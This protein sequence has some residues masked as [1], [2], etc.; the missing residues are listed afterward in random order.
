[1]FRTTEEPLGFWQWLAVSGV[2]ETVQFQGGW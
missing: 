2:R 1:M